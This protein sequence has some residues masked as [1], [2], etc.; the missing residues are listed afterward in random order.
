VR[1]AFAE[2]G[3]NL[4]APPP[5]PA[6][7]LRRVVQVAGAGT[8]AAVVLSVEP[9]GERSLLKGAL[10]SQAKGSYTGVESRLVDPRNPA[11]VTEEAR[12]LGA[13]MR[14]MAESI[15]PALP[16]WIVIPTKKKDDRVP[17][18]PPKK[19][20]WY[21]RWY[22]WVATGGLVVTAAIVLPLTLRSKHVETTIQW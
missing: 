17:V 12:K 18:Q 9:T 10:Y 3:Q 8:R 19:R 7:S 1:A 4:P 14:R 13:Q 16:K 22:T 5:P 20:P 21:K 11:R 15:Y 2:A 6:D